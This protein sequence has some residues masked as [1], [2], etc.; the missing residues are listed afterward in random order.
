MKSH[1]C[2][3]HPGDLLRLLLFP[4]VPV[5]LFAVAA[6]AGVRF[7]LWP[8][9]RPTLDTERT[10][11]IHQAESARRNDDAELLLLGDS[12][13][14]MDVSARQLGDQ[15]GRPALNLATF[16]FLDLDAH[17]SMLREFV[18]ANPGGLRAVVLLMNPESLRRASAEPYYATAL[19][20]FWNARDHSQATTF[21]H[22]AAA[23]LGVDIFKGRFLARA[24]PVP[25]DGA[26]GRRYGFTR[27]LEEFMSLERGSAIDPDRQPFTGNAEYRLAP[28][29]ERASREFR[30]T[31]PAG[32]K[33]LVGMTPVPERLAG[34]RFSIVQPQLLRQ[35]SGWLEGEALTELP[36]T[37]SDDLF[38]RT[39]HLDETAVPRYTELLAAAVKTHLTLP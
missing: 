5:M 31:V 26:Y 11:L 4:I 15:L 39:T 33:I 1:H 12:S 3:F 36:G 24:L 16:S 29:L 2:E 37:L 6:H 22:Q 28:T 9:P 23:L 35:W 21:S 25:L 13:C 18:K 32:V 27:D 20:N 14:L 19:T 7:N 38:V 8:A 17:A 34:V 10:I 30:K